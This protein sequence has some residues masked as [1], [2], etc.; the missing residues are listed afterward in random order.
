MTIGLKLSKRIVEY[1]KQVAS[2]DNIKQVFYCNFFELL[3]NFFA[4]NWDDIKA[5]DESLIEPNLRIGEYWHV[6]TYI[7]VHGHILIERGAFEEV[8]KLIDKLSEIWAS[9]EDENAK[10]YQ[11]TLRIKKL[12]K[13]RRLHNALI[14]AD[15]GLSF[16]SKTGRLFSTVYYLGCKVI[17]QILLK[18][19][20]GAR[21]TLSQTIEI[22]SK[23]GRIP[24]FYINSFL[25]GQFYLDLDELKQAILA[26][27]TADI[28]KN[29]KKAAISGK[30]ALKN[31]VKSALDRTEIFRL[32]GTYCW[33]VNR[34]NKAMKWWDKSIG[35]SQRFGS[36]I[37][38]ARTEM[39][40]GKHLAEDKG[41]FRKDGEIIAEK[42]LASARIAFQE[43]KL[44]WDIDELDEI[45]A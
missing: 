13:S 18:D 30:Q 45:V 2:E 15:A 42:Y 25:I 21:Q 43:M 36:R 20:G 23:I 16:Q 7:D 34:K 5:Y 28:A 41:R 44:Q 40:I 22:I 12:L 32:M 14:E 11:Y 37:E 24:P 1:A 10:H 35:E 29:R 31:S 17:I 33:L 19:L 39:E 26:G 38:A 9:Y 6:S 8:E 27:N 4:G 3:Y